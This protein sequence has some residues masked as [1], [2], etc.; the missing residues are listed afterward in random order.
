MRK[1]DPLTKYILHKIFVLRENCVIKILGK[2][3]KGKSTIAMEIAWRVMS[4]LFSIEL[5]VWY[6]EMFSAIYKKGVKRGD[7]IMYE[8]IGT[9]AGGLPRRRWYEFNN[10]LLLDIMQTHGFEGTVM[11]LTLPSS[12]YLDSNT[13]PLIDIEIEAKKIDRRNNLN[14]FTAYEVEW[15]EDLKETYKHCFVDEN[16]N[17]I[18]LFAWKRTMP[19]ELIADYKKA[20]K[21]FK[22]YVQKR[23]NELIRKKQITPEDESSFFN[24]IMQDLESFT[25]LRNN[26]LY[27]NKSLIE[28]EFNIGRRI[29]NKIKLKVEREILENDDYLEER[30][31]LQ[32]YLRKK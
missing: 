17:K 10:L 31:M 11:I 13:E 4:Y 28:S 26:K 21:E 14:Y 18:E 5:V 23:V 8:E 29:S 20:E 27:V 7:V 25:T 22:R 32:T 3:Q 1:A 19:K 6:P 30:A 2:L 12:K 15:N 9:E 24:D 16:G